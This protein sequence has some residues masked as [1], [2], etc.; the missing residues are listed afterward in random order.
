MYTFPASER[1]LGQLP[2]LAEGRAP[3]ALFCDGILFLFDRSG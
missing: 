2:A 3:P 1:L